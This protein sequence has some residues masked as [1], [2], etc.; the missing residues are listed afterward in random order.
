MR[1]TLSEEF[2]KTKVKITCEEKLGKCHHKVG[3]SYVYAHAL[4]YPQGLCPG[5][6]EP[7]RIYVSHCAAGV[8]SWE[9]DDPSI[10]RIHCISKK[11]TVWKLEKLSKDE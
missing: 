2:W 9:G 6:Q 10:H 3:D 5:V 8:P 11:G 4:D 7:A 1:R